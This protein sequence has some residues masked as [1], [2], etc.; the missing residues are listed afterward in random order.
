[1][2]VGHFDS[3]KGTFHLR[4]GN[5]LELKTNIYLIS[6][7]LIIVFDLETIGNKPNPKLI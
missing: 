2:G 4:G 3:T 1:M 6:G 5:A 7:R